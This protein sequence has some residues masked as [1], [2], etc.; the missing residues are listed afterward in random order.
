MP[1]ELSEAMNFARSFASIRPVRKGGP[2]SMRL[3]DQTARPSGQMQAM[4]DSGAF[5]LAMPA[6]PRSKK[7]EIAGGVCDPRSKGTRISDRPWSSS[8]AAIEETKARE[9]RTRAAFIE[10]R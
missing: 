7:T 1:L 2:P 8:A 10:G 6:Y 5:F 3:R 9:A 4:I